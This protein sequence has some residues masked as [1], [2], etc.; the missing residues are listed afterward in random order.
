MVR[1]QVLAVETRWTRDAR[2]IRLARYRAKASAKRVGPPSTSR[3][4]TSM[5]ASSIAMAAP[6]AM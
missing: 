5:A 1:S 6:W 3:Q 4:R 2:S